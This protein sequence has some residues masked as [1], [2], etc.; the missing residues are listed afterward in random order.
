VS[1]LQVTEDDAMLIM[2]TLSPIIESP[3][4]GIEKW[5]DGKGKEVDS[6]HLLL[7]GN[8]VI[9]KMLETDNPDAE[10]LFQLLK[11]LR[12]KY[13]IEKVTEGSG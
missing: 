11:H 10:K 2:E 5:E 6:F 1:E 7:G 13:N 12:E 3:R 8:H 4:G 9:L